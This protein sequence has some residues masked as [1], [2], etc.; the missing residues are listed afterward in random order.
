MGDWVL[1]ITGNLHLAAVKKLHQRFVG[2]FQV[3]QHVCQ[4][5][6]KLDLKGKFVGVHDVFYV[7]QL[8]P[9]IPDVCW[10]RG[11]LMLACVSGL[12]MGLGMQ[13]QEESW[14]CRA[15]KHQGSRAKWR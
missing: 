15:M 6:Y 5:A 1:L 10:Q 9:H 13:M 8:R 7:S 3:I 4:T 2:P 11:Y 14:L 12:M